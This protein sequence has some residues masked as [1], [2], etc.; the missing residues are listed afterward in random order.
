MLR[1]L[2]QKSDSKRSRLYGLV[3][4]SVGGQRIAARAEEVDGVSHWPPTMLVPSETPFV[5]SVARRGKEVLPVFD[6]A[7]RL[8]AHVQ[9][10]APLCLVVK[11]EDGPMAICVDEEIPA[12]QMAEPS[13]IQP[14]SG[15][16]PDIVATYVGETDRIPVYSLATLGKVGAAK[17]ST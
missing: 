2:R 7:A 16:D 3:V 13:A 1:G 9:G 8:N 10:T 17:T 5:G 12:L 14:Y 6:F 15:P 4:F 11:H